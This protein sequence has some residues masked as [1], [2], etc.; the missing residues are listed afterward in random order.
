MKENGARDSGGKR[1][2]ATKGEGEGADEEEE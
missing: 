1:G 2:R